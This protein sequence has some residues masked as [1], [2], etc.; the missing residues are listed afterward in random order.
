MQAAVL[1]GT[2]Q[3]VNKVAKFSVATAQTWATPLHL[4]PAQADG[5]TFAWQPMDPQTAETPDE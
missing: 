2:I 5:Q 3:S 1:T 4:N